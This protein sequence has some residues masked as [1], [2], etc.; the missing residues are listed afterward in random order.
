MVS[1]VHARVACGGRLAF[2]A[3]NQTFVLGQAELALPARALAFY[4]EEGGG[5]RP[6]L[7]FNAFGE[8]R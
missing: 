8:D 6:V 1:G 3:F 5:Y 7:L 2:V 4:E